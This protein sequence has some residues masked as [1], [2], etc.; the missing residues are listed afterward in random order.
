[1]FT[2]HSVHIVPYS[3]SDSVYTYSLQSNSSDILKFVLY[4][5]GGPRGGEE[6]GGGEGRRGQ[7]CWVGGGG[8]TGLLYTPSRTGCLSTCPTG[9]QTLSVEMC[10]PCLC[11]AGAGEM[12]RQM[13]ILLALYCT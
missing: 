10:C 9:D 11:E 7:N 12:R 4:C 8:T 2:V 13:E 6:G 5:D 3:N 1:M